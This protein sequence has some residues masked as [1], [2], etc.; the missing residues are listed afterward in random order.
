[1]VLPVLLYALLMGCAW[2]VDQRTLYTTEVPDWAAAGNRGFPLWRQLS[3]TARTRGMLL[4][5]WHVVPGLTVY[6]QVES[7]AGPP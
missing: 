6:T 1:M 4:R 5:P 3:Y 7:G 2:V